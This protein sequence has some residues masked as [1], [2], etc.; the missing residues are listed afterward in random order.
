MQFL[1]GSW[2][3]LLLE[4]G[5]QTDRRAPRPKIQEDLWPFKAAHRHAKFVHQHRRAWLRAAYCFSLWTSSKRK[6]I[7]S[8]PTSPSPVVLSLAPFSS[9]HSENVSTSKSWQHIFSGKR[10]IKTK[11]ERWV[12]KLEIP[13][14][15][16]NTSDW[17]FVAVVSA[18]RESADSLCF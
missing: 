8:A 5:R 12:S 15:S 4:K 9:L 7:S 3:E 6:P 18:T 2:T 11:I 17:L 10:Q 14:F 16:E 13:S 1:D